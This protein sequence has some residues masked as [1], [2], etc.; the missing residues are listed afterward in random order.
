MYRNEVCVISSGAFQVAASGGTDVDVVVCMPSPHAKRMVS[1]IEAVKLLGEKEKPEAVT[2]I[3]LAAALKKSEHNRRLTSKACFF[4]Q[5]ILEVKA[6]T[7]GG[8]EANR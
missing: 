8:G 7:I 6:E 3:F 1:P 5:T 4:I 2:R